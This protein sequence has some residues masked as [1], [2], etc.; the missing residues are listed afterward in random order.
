MSYVPKMLNYDGYFI[1][2]HAS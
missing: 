2:I 1:R